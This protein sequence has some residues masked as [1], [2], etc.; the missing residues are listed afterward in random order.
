MEQFLSN[1]PN[2]LIS[3][4]VSV[5]IYAIVLWFRSG[6]ADGWG[7][8]FKLLKTEIPKK[9]DTDGDGDITDEVFNLLKSIIAK[10]QKADT[11]ELKQMQNTLS[12]SLKAHD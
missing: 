8:L 3:G 5:L 12:E 1:I 4:I 10:R 6:R 7:G 9:F 2:E 11:P